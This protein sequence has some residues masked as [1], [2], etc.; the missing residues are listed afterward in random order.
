MVSGKRK[1]DAMTYVA[2]LRRSLV[3]IGTIFPESL[4][5]AT[6]HAVEI[7]AVEAR[8]GGVPY[9]EALQEVTACKP[10]LLDWP[11][12]VVV[13]ATKQ[14]QGGMIFLEGDT[15]AV[16]LFRATLETAS[17]KEYKPSCLPETSCIISGG[18]ESWE[19]W[20]S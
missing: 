6:F 13:Y 7:G 11:A 20:Y 8:R 10:E 3:Y 16:F 4:L 5:E 12:A 1:G 2:P 15:S 9:I 14:E 17:Y 19:I 18:D